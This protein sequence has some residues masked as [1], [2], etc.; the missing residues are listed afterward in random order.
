MECRTVKEAKEQEYRD[1]I[2]EHI[3]NVQKTFRNITLSD[4]IMNYLNSMATTSDPLYMRA[5][6]NSIQDHDKS[7]FGPEEFDAYRIEYYPVND[8]EKANNKQNMDAAW[9]HHYTNNKHHWDSWKSCPDLM[10]MNCE[11]EMI[12]DWCAMSMKF[13]GKTIDWY[14]KQNNIVLGAKQRKVVE[15][16]LAMYRDEFEI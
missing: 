16:V 6:E 4:K 8:A 14:K 1:Y 10:P 13:G 12:C 7:K 2:T 5:L 11:V 9:K 3:H 15:T